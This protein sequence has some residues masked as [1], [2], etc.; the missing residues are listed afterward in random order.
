PGPVRSAAKA[1]LNYLQLQVLQLANDKD[2]RP[3]ISGRQ[4][5]IQAVNAFLQASQHIFR[6]ERVAAEGYLRRA[7]ELDPTFIEPRVWLIPGLV[8]QNKM[9]EALEHYQELLKLNAAASPFEQA[10]IAWVRARLDRD[11]AG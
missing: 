4:Q 6:Y 3:W 1:V 5:N 11:T 9:P 2:L 7:I 8:S 10:M